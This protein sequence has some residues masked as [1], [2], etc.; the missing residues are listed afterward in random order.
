VV[1][2]GVQLAGRRVD[3]EAER[4][5]IRQATDVEWLEAGQAKDLEGWVSFYTDDAAL[6]PPNAPIVTGKE[7]I[8]A[9]VSA[10][11]STP[12]FA[13]TWQTTKIEVSRS[14]DL[15]YSYGTEETTVNDAEGNPVTDRQ[16]WV[17][18][19]KKQPDGSWKCVVEILNSDQP[20]PGAA[21]D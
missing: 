3:I 12:G 7:A 6:L 5:A 18:V 8:R 9:F 1:I 10:L 13:A 2:L 16:K 11:F 14:G 4:A 15:A 21:T 19:W 17:V 20:P